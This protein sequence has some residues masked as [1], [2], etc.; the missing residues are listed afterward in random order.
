[1]TTWEI[2]E[3]PFVAE[4]GTGKNKYLRYWHVSPSGDHDAD[5]ELG[6]K[7]AVLAVR[8]MRENV[9]LNLNTIVSFMPPPEKHTGIESGFFAAIGYMATHGH[10]EAAYKHFNLWMRNYTKNLERKE[11]AARSERA[12]KAAKAR[13]A[14]RSRT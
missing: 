5:F 8:F 2:T 12:R 6:G 7:Y 4:V 14:K 10:G 13:G 3:L 9:M 1:M 11:K